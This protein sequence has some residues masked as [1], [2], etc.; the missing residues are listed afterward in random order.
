MYWIL[1][2]VLTQYKL[3]FLDALSREGPTFIVEPPDSVNFANDTGTVIPCSA[4]GNPS[5]AVTWTKENGK[6]VTNVPGLR[7]VRPDGSLVFTR[8]G[9][10]EYQQEVHDA[11]YRC[12]ASNVVG[13][14]GSRIVRVKGVILQSFRLEVNNNY[15]V[16]G[17]TGVLRC[18][19][20]DF[21]KEYVT[22]TSWLQDETFIIRGSTTAS[23]FSV[24]PSG[25]F[26]VRRVTASDVSKTFRCQVQHH[27]TGETQT[28]TTSGRFVVTDAVNMPPRLTHFKRHVLAV[29]GE[30]VEIP[31]AAQGSPIPTYK[32]FKHIH[33]GFNSLTS[34]EAITVLDGTLVMHKPTAEDTGK[35]RCVVRNSLGSES[36]D[37]E[38]VVSAHLSVKIYPR[39][40]IVDV[41]KTASFNFNYSGYPI[42]SIDWKKDNMPLQ[43]NDRAHLTGGNGLR[44]FPVERQDK[45]MYQCFIRNQ[46][47]TVQAASELRIGDDEPVFQQVFQEQ[48]LKPG[49]SLSLKC[50]SQGNP[51]PQVTWLLDGMPLPMNPRFSLGDYVTEDQTVTSYV[52]I[53]NVRPEDG[54]SY[55]CI[56]KNDVSE[57]RHMEQIRVYGP[58]FIRPMKNKSVLTG[59]ILELQCPVG[60]YP[61]ESIVWKREGASLP[62]NH[63]QKVYTNGTL[64]VQNVDRTTDEGTYVCQAN[65]KE[66]R[67]AE[68]S[69]L[70][71]VLVRPFIEPFRFPPSLHFGQRFNVMCVVTKGDPPVDIRWLKDGRNIA[72]YLGIRELRVTDF[73]S[74]LV[75]DSVRPEYNGNYTCQAS[76]SAGISNHTATMVIH[77]PP[78]WKIEPKNI[79][80]TKGVD[81][82]LDCQA[83]GFPAPNI[84]W[85]KAKGTEEPGQYSSITSNSHLHVYDN[86]TLIIYKSKKEDAGFYLCEATNGVVPSISKVVE[87]D[88]N[89]PPHF[90]NKFQV[91]TVRKGREVNLECEAGGDNPITILWLKNKQ[92]LDVKESKRHLLTET[93]LPD[94]K[95]SHLHIIDPDRSD[96]GIFSCLASNAFGHDETNIQLI[97]QEPPDNPQSVKVVSF[98]SRSVTLSWLPPFTGNSPIT[99]Y[100]VQWKKKEDKWQQQ[101]S[102]STIRGNETTFIISNLL[103]FTSYSFRVFAVNRLGT[104]EASQA[105]HAKSNEEAPGGPPVHVQAEATG[106]QSIKVTWKSPE[107]HLHYGIIR[108]YYVGYKLAESVDTYIYQTLKVNDLGFREESHLTNLRRYTKYAVVVQAYNNKGTGPP[109]EETTVRTLEN[110]PPF[111]PSLKILATTSSTVQFLVTSKDRLTN[112]A[113]SG[114]FLYCKEERS[115]WKKVRIP[116]DTS[117]YKVRNLKC[118]TRYL[119]YIEAFNSAGKGEPSET[120]TVITKGMAPIP[121]SKQS[122]LSINS[123]WVNIHLAAWDNGVCP[124]SYFSL[125]YKVETDNTWRILSDHVGPLQKDI[126]LSNLSYMTRYRLQVTAKSPAGITEAE[127]G[128]LTLPASSGSAAPAEIMEKEHIPLYLDLNIILPVSVSLM[129]VVIIITTVYIILRRQYPREGSTSESTTYSRR[130]LQ[131]QEALHMMNVNRNSKNLGSSGQGTT[132]YYPEPYATTRL[133]TE[134]E[135]DLIEATAS[136][137]VFCSTVDLFFGIYDEILRNIT[138]FEIALEGQGDQSKTTSY[139]L[140]EEK[141]VSMGSEIQE[142]DARTMEEGVIQ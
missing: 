4:Q 138:S 87:L 19:I 125:R 83:R 108:G 110:D 3:D 116:P 82:K 109:S 2:F 68:N 40:Q 24:F 50:V 141:T 115:D 101:S 88:I 57:V 81:S 15:V 104:S 45:G 28:S 65:D 9:A 100:I 99:E 77:V 132:V 13:T 74:T 12:V 61:I 119:F 127:Y 117:E 48:T 120:V 59:E 43:W 124:I 51:L 26:H 56:A 30:M 14:V 6:I 118:G 121:P 89:E 49:A 106:A 130:K 27:L 139:H 78:T 33:G 39:Y 103:P 133:S 136:I 67:T 131:P 142:L 22:V 5:P 35:Y 31:C 23:R 107:K 29:E 64:I 21:V 92:R 128:F 134:E 34:G 70:I 140:N 75:F 96:S 76:N 86:G 1:V 62:Y 91:E 60:G 105:V 16:S 84:H 52:N 137:A 111:Q 63:R 135:S 98:T 113:L 38:L 55:Q 46:L 66:G 32:W 17:N 7:Y 41:G 44:I 73:S 71:S 37:I 58:P 69:I 54:G 11:T 10:T 129:V 18:R 79:A 122:L 114:F 90:N 97:I 25:E 112:N 53:S 36:S 94:G 72:D 95:T 47:G 93:L 85:S 20:P 102:N 80:V 126:V 8:F 42:L 123:T